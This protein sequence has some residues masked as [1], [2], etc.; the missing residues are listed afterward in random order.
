MPILKEIKENLK[1]IINIEAVTKTYQEIANLRMNK[2]R[3][4][5]LGNREL[6][7]ELSRIYTLAKKVYAAQSQNK[8][9]TKAR[10]A[11]IKHKRQRVIVFLSCNERFHGTL[12]LDI[13]KEIFNFL[14]ENKADLAVV[15]RIG[16]YLAER[17]RL[18]HKMFYFE[19]DDDEPEKERIKGIIEFIKNYREIIIFHGRFQTILFQKVVQSDISGGTIQE[20]ELGEIKNYL[21]E[22]S[23]EAVLDFFE[24]ELISAFFNQTILEHRLSRYATR[25][26][27]MY[28]ATRSAK[29]KRRELEIEQKKLIRQLLNK[30][31]VEMFS[32]LQ[33]WT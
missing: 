20:K 26:I 2:I 15:G 24:T 21:F 12:I 1:T 7:D 28:Q 11:S 9:T 6:I 14:T 18:G 27:A 22:P 17:G 16:K 3:Q 5:V 10:E 31:Q 19:L 8:K 25:M 33:L 23:P 30:K 32:G 4:E 13:W 29:E